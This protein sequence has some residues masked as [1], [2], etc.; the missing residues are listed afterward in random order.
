MAEM[1]GFEPTTYG[2][3]VRRYYQLSYISIINGGGRGNRAH[4]SQWQLIYSQ[5]RLLNG[6]YPRK[7]GINRNILQTLL[8][9]RTFGSRFLFACV[10]D[11]SA[12]QVIVNIFL[13]KYGWHGETWTHTGFNTRRIFLL[14]Y[15]TIAAETAL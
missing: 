6:L 5:P 9:Q 1:V 2:L 11:F 14:L 15:I 4:S 3:T 13:N 12:V 7:C 8:T 10:I